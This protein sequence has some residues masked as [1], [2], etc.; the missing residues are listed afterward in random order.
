[1]RAAR[2]NDFLRSERG[3]TVL[4]LA[5]LIFLLALP[6]LV[7][8]AVLHDPRWYPLG[9]VAQTELRIRDVWSRHPPLIG[10]AGRVGSL[11]DQASHPGPL[12]FW[13]LWPTWRLFGASAWGMQ[14]ATGFLNML[15]MGAVVWMA[16]RRGGIRLAIA[17][18]AVL[19]LLAAAFG[20]ALV[21]AWNPY[22][23]VLWWVTFVA[24]IWCVVCDDL[25]LL[26][27]AVFAGSFCMQTHAS[28][29]GLVPGLLA[30]GVVFALVTAYRNRESAAVARFW[31]WTGVA[32]AVGVVL[33]IPPVIDEIKRSPGNLSVLRDTFTDSPDE[34]IGARDGLEL[35]LV[36]L[37]PWRVLA[38][39]DI[40]TGSVQGSIV[41]GLIVLAVW[42]GAAVVARRVGPRP[43]TRLNLVIGVALVLGLISASRI[44]GIVWPYLA[45]WAWGLSVLMWLTIGWTITIVIGRGLDDDR[46]ARALSVGTYGLVAVAVIV[47]ASFVV[48]AADMEPANAD[49]SATLGELVGP[50]VDALDEDGTYLVTWFD[51]VAIGSQGF[52]LVDELERQGFDVGALEVHQGGITRHR[53][54]DPS[55]A[56]AVVHLSIGSD[57]EVW[58]AKPGVE[59]VA[60]VDPRTP[61]QRDEFEGLRAQVIA[62]L[63]DQG[64]DDLVPLVDSNLFV[65]ATD[66]SVPLEIRERV[67]R[68][69]EL[70]L[71]A[72]IFVGPPDALD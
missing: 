54:I 19:G 69:G 33:W 71:P 16:H 49:L 72:A 66:T 38:R 5:G 58:R 23:P 62:E 65:V 36:H 1:M 12:S 25:L 42:I 28:Y 59:E 11:G 13:S 29:L 40:T 7:G 51:P 18:T 21:E 47:S 15:A 44:F 35:V 32:G 20:V 56:T 2:V 9:D 63:Q 43:L 22:L 26:P 67:A 61:E 48:D 37:N 45:L 31:R 10:L 3:R 39:Q 8:L 41:P 57:I 53:V 52:G 24:A 17:V 55:E 50:T 6:L 70:K 46:R 14:V 27:V 34:P 64:F 68:M 30:F 4:V 60:Y